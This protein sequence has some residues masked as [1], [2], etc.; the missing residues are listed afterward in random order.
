MNQGI[1]TQTPSRLTVLQVAWPIILSNLSTPLLGLVDTAVIGNLGDAA[2]IGAI[3]IGAMIFSFLYWGFGFLRMGTTGLVAQALGA[4]DPTEVVASFY[5]ALL[6]AAGIGVALFCLQLPLATLAFRLIDGS[7]A[8][9]SAAETYFFIRILGAPL[10]LANLAIAGLLL[11]Q[12]HTRALLFIQLLLNG[13]NILLDLVFVVGL[14]LGVAGVAAATVIA[15]AVAFVAGMMM[16]LRSLQ[17][18]GASLTLPISRLQDASA[19]RRMFSVNRDIMIRTLCL[20]F[21]FAWFTN[22]GAKAGDTVLAANAIL[23]QFVSF[24]AFFLDGF[25]L[26]AETLVGNAVGARS[27]NRLDAAIRYS[28]EL[29]LATALLLT[30][31]LILFAPHAITL[32]TNVPEVRL[33]AAA[34]LPWAA[35]APLVSVWC[36]QLDGIFIGATRTAEMRNAMIVSLAVFLGAWALLSAEF[37]NHGLWASLLVYFVARA[38]SLQYYL[39]RLKSAVGTS[40]PWTAGTNPDTRV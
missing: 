8:V 20:I 1:Q 11:G 32:L 3:A 35:L 29:A 21:A 36:Y 30:L 19:L 39:P 31:L 28:T 24:S 25:A 6:V 37:G 10:S 38:A 16:V 27:R 33:A 4:D 2:L 9:E 13:T 40:D 34:F 23:M 17:A 12:Q 26:A 5:R 14:G 7:S 18:T 15:E 22:Q